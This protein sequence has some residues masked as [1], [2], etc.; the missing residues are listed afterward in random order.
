MPLLARSPEELTAANVS[1]STFDSLGVFVGPSIAAFLL[2]LSGPGA[3]ARVQRGDLRL[4]RLLHRPRPHAG[5]RAAAR[6]RR[7]RRL[8]GGLVGGVQGDRRRAAAPAPDRPLRR[9]VLR[10][11]RLGVFV[12]VIA[13]KLLGLG[14]AGVGLLQAA[15]GIGCAR[16]ARPSRCRSSPRSA[17]RRRLRASGSCSGVR[18]WCS[19]ALRRRAI[20]AALAL[21]IV[22]V[23]NTLV[24]ISAMTL[25]Q[26]A[27]PPDVA[28]AR[29]RL[30]RERDRRRRSRSARSRLPG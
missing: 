10:R 8:R 28:G 1:S 29:L 22:G 25:L 18:R 26:R 19:S 15:C 3:G 23:G 2:A 9:A 27:A 24:D 4:E 14:T 20:V 21:G 11:R 16:S 7:A 13:L 30:P 6:G 12:V 17:D 5:R